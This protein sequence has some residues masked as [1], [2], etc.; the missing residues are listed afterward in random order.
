MSGTS[1]GKW[2]TSIIWIALIV[3]FV[4]LITMQSGSKQPR[5]TDFEHFRRLVASGSVSEVWADGNQIVYQ[6]YNDPDRQATAG[7]ID[8]DLERTISEAGTAFHRTPPPAEGGSNGWLRVL[9][10]VAV[11][12]FVVLVLLRSAGQAGRL[13][14][15]VRLRP[16]ARAARC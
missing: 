3:V 5:Q 9:I 6:L 7:L 1:G 11:V 10:I 14:R 12:A 2:K 15:R 16:S 4:A 13:F 8:S